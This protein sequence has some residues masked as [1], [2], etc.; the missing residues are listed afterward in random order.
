M[1]DY[2]VENFSSFAEIYMSGMVSAYILCLAFLF[3]L[4]VKPFVQ[5]RRAAYISAFVY[6]V[7]RFIYYLI[8]ISNDFL[9]GLSLL[10]IIISFLALWL[11][12]NK[13]NPIQKFFICMLFYVMSF[14]TYEMSVELSLFED[15]FIK[16]LDIYQTDVG[17][18]VI[19]FVISN[20][21]DYALAFV[22]MFISIRIIQRVYK[23][24]ADE[25]SWKELLMLITPFWTILI[26]RYIML[27]YFELW[28]DGIGNGS[29][30]ENIPPSVFR[31][32]FCVLSLLS[33]LII[34]VSYQ[35]ISESKEDEFANKALEDRTEDIR[36]HMGQI[37]DMYEKMRG[38]RHDIGNHLTVIEGLAQS[39]KTD[40][41]SE[42][43][44]EL[45]ARFDELQPLVKT[46]NAVTDVVLSETLA[47][48][49]REKI[50]FE[51]RFVYP[52]E[53]DINPFDMSVILSNSLHNAIEAAKCSENPRISV[54]SVI[55]DKVYI[56]NIKNT[57]S[58]KVVLNE[59]GLPETTKRETGHGYGLKNIRNIAW[60]YKG[61]LE[62]RQEESDGDL[63]FVLN[64][65]L[66][67]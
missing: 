44:G 41:L 35:K 20:F 10:I 14:L 36:R 4:W 60:K 37:E 40:E 56:I 45:Q 61:D 29:I 31:L 18:I 5:K 54:T 12:D 42:Y 38:L 27:A 62:I 50:R 47:N 55:K 23:R 46:G 7:F 51:S 33:T 26:V 34:I 1:I 48:C 64:V 58:D 13:R 63:C 2:L 49:R 28:M 24:K 15:R 65:M 59:D 19:E 66:M 9:R 30:T 21:I 67:G 32:S 8:P 43:V 25:M 22:I 6:F 53:L 39:G 16:K 57:I 17:A 11:S 52:E 3:A